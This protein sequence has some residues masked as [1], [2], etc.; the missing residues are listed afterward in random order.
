VT[1]DN[2]YNYV[3]VDNDFAQLS[4]P[5]ETVVAKRE[6][7]ELLDMAGYFKYVPHTLH[8]IFDA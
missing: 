4:I 2:P 7:M 6:K 3:T 5:G 1:P 8:S